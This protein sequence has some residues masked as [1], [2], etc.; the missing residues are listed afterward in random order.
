MKDNN[1]A[2][3]EVLIRID[4]QTGRCTARYNVNGTAHIHINVLAALMSAFH[5]IIKEPVEHIAGVTGAPIEDVY[6]RIV[7]VSEAMRQKKDAKS[8]RAV[9]AGAFMESL[10]R[11]ANGGKQ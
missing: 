3:G 10:L 11:Q 1:E 5:S 2:R 6:M 7:R 8:G 4:A 9:D